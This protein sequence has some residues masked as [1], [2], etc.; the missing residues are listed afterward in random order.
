MALPCPGAPGEDVQNQ[1]GAVDDLRRERSLQIPLLGRAQFL[2]ENDRVG[3]G[4]AGQLGQF[5]DLSPSNQSRGIR[6]RTR[7]YH[8]VFDCCPGAAGEGAKLGQRL[9]C[10]ILG[11]LLG[12]RHSRTS[13]A[14]HFQ[15]DQNNVL[16]GL[17]YRMGNLLLH[18]I[19]GWHP[20][21]RMGWTTLSTRLG[22][23]GRREGVGWLGNDDGRDGVFED[24]LFLVVRFE[25]DGVLVE[26]LDA[27]GKLYPAHQV[28]REKSLLFARVI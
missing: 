20:R 26:T 28:D 7:L 24:Q 25:N 5:L 19:A 2:I 22:L 15:P 1:L 9:L 23:R 17:L 27:A 11:A 16:A 18:E 12:A 21:S 8:P 10:R 14:A 3:I 4:G 6:R 13:S